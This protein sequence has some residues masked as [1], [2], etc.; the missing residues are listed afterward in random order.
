MV[1]VYYIVYLYCSSLLK[2]K[3]RSNTRKKVFD[4]IWDPFRTLVF[5]VRWYF[6]VFVF[7]GIVNGFPA[8]ALV[9]DKITFILVLVLLFGL[10]DFP[11]RSWLLGVLKLFIVCRIFA[12]AIGPILAHNKQF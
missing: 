3:I 11:F 10:F 6:P 12:V 9:V 1:L 8:V 5:I 7:V 4:A 2:L